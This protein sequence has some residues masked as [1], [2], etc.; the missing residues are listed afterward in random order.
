MSFDEIESVVVGVSAIA[1][2]FFS[3][4]IWRANI[5]SAKA[6]KGAADAAEESAKISKLMLEAEEEKRQ[7]LRDQIKRDILKQTSYIMNILNEMKESSMPSLV[8]SKLPETINNVSNYELA[9]Y[10][11]MKER[12]LIYYTIKKYES[13]R[14]DYF[15]DGKPNFT[16]NDK[17]QKET[18]ELLDKTK[19][20]IIEFT[21]K[22][23]VTSEIEIG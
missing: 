2:S 13:Y 23:F 17:F 10:F 19:D 1:T 18:Q 21:E 6:A 7:N 11:S 20:V 4:L 9:H 3:F 8:M 12:Q 15:K 22:I 16:L 14:N 5:Q